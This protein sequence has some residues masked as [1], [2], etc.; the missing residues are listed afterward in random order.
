[1]DGAGGRN[2]AGCKWTRD[3]RAAE[4]DLWWRRACAPGGCGK[5]LGGWWAEACSATEPPP[6]AASSSLWTPV[7]TIKTTSG[8]EAGEDPHE[9]VNLSNDRGRRNELRGLSRC[10]LDYEA[11][12]LT[13]TP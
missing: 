7:A 9:L 1:M 4:T 12:E 3:Q 5:L 6:K 11:E 13:L 10:L 8:N 2:D